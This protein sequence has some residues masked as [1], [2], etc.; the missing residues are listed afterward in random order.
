MPQFVI[1]N[2]KSGGL[3]TNYFCSSSC[4]HCLYNCSPHWEKQYIDPETACNNLA[5]IRLMGCRSVHIGGGEPLL[6]PQELKTVLEVASEIGVSIEY[7][8]TN[9]SWFKEKDAAAH[10]LAELRVKGLHTLLVSISP[11]HNEHIPFFKVK[12]VI[13]AAQLA[14]VGV[15]PWVS[16]FVSDLSNFDPTK[17]HSLD[18]YRKVYGNNYLLEVLNRYWIHFGGRALD[19]FRPLLG[20][21]TLKQI[22]DE[23][24]GGCKAELKDTSHFHMDLFGN[25]IPGLC[26]GLAISSTDLGSRL[27]TEKYPILV[28]LYSEGI[29]GLVSMAAEKFDFTPQG[30]NYINKCD[31]CTEIRTHMVNSDYKESS[32]LNPAGFY[33]QIEKN[34]RGIK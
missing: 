29:R 4:R 14:G 9:S 16:D 11:F 5:K 24:P 25:Y 20:K 34:M 32:E 30:N 12:G 8:E 19:T 23:N 33:T 10:L 3:I 6:R 26:S 18:E 17:T 1:K 7:V 27:S 28:T 13:E 22:L 2:L 21:K 31:L 15:F